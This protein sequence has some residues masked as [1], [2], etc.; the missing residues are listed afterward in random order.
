MVYC[1]PTEDCPDDDHIIERAIYKDTDGV[2]WSLA[3]V[4]EGVF[5][6]CLGEVPDS[7]FEV[8]P[9]RMKEFMIKNTNCI[10][11]QNTEFELFYNLKELIQ[12]GST[13]EM[14]SAV[15]AFLEE[16][17]SKDPSILDCELEN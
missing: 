7:V 17:L 9:E 16:R 5:L 14:W 13:Y 12:K 3:R 15:V 2:E 1:L 11:F 10:Y 8:H 6:S 4:D